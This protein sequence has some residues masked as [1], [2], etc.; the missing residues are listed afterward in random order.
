M[1]FKERFESASL[2]GMDVKYEI[3]TSDYTILGGFIDTLE[4]D[5]YTEELQLHTIDGGTTLL[6][7]A[8]SETL[9]DD[10]DDD[11]EIWMFGN[12]R[13]VFYS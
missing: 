6:L 11:V 3:V 1:D 9:I 5:D 10:Q 12:L 8:A 7:H 4:Y 2:N 13:I